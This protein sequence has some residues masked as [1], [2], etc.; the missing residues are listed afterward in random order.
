MCA[1]TNRL[2]DILSQF[3]VSLLWLSIRITLA[4]LMMSGM[5]HSSNTFS[6][7]PSI[8]YFIRMTSSPLKRNG[9]TPITIWMTC[10][11]WW[12]ALP[13]WTTAPL[14]RR[15]TKSHW[16]QKTTSIKF[17]R[18]WMSSTNESWVKISSISSIRWLFKWADIFRSGVLPTDITNSTNKFLYLIPAKRAACRYTPRDTWSIIK[19]FLYGLSNF[20]VLMGFSCHFKYKLLFNIFDILITKLLLIFNFDFSS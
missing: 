2:D 16:W 6:L 14:R 7:Q 4:S 5:T 9:W 13:F 3:S 8:P 20:K 10:T 18:H 11:I 15:S 17:W 12:P 1:F 19:L